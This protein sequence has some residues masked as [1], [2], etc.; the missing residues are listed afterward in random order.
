M[1]KTTF[2]IG[3]CLAALVGA[4]NSNGTCIQLD[5][6]EGESS[7]NISTCVVHSTSHGCEGATTKNT[8]YPEDD[9][10]GT[11][12]CKQGGFEG[13]KPAHL[14]EPTP[15]DQIFYHRSKKQ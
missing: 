10:A 2:S 1:S 7:T 15:D 6:H 11:I 5:P 13:G 14:G 12:R 4:C 3:A 9:A 8:F